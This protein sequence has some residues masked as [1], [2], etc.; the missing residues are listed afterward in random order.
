MSQLDERL[1]DVN[2]YGVL[3]IPGI[4]WLGL[5]VQ[6]RHWVLLLLV[7]TST[8][9]GS[10]D[11]ARQGFAAL[12]PVALLLELPSLLVFVA[13][14]MRQPNAS[15]FLRQVWQQGAMLMT[16]TSLLGLAWLTW[17]L[18]RTDTWQRW[19]E[20]YFASTCLLDLAIALWINT[21]ELAKKVFSEFPENQ[22]T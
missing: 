17:W 8:V 1:F 16:A 11:S 9:V 5:L 15:K 2:Q 21:S 3:R 14:S 7:L 19:P 22:K 13:A 18:L 6:N 12:S 10:V 4:L 20:L